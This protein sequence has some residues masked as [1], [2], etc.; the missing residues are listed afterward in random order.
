MQ[1]QNDSILMDFFKGEDREG[2]GGDGTFVCVRDGA[3][4]RVREI[5]WRKRGGGWVGIGAPCVGRDKSI[6]DSAVEPRKAW[7]ARA[8]SLSTL[9]CIKLAGTSD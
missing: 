3:S 9:L 6:L 1:Q 2:G 4:P 5:G 7:P 8:I